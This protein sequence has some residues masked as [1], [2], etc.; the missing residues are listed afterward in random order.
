V[1][2]PLASGYRPTAIRAIGRTSRYATVS[3]SAHSDRQVAVTH[4]TQRRL[5][6]ALGLIW[7]ADGALQFQP[8]MFGRS[9]VTKIIAPNAI[10]EPGLVA[11]PVR[12]MAHLIEPRVALFNVFAA[13]IQVLIGLSAARP[14]SA[15]LRPSA[16]E[17]TRSEAWEELQ[18]GLGG[19]A[20]PRREHRDLAVHRQATHR[21]QLRAD[22]A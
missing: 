2:R 3:A 17:L 13:T 16:G 4:G 10:G 15:R 12:F 1:R 7:L 18:R 6:I 8:F 20:A 11:G 14:H 9:F 21:R 22:P 5:Q 19:A